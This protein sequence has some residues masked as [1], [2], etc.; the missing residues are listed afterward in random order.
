MIACACAV[1]AATDRAG[2]LVLDLGPARL[3]LADDHQD[4]LEQVDRL[5]PRD[6]DRDAVTFGE[7]RVLLE[8]HHGA[9]VPGGEEPLH[10]VGRRRE[11]GLHRG[12]DEDVRDQHRE[13]R[14]AQPPRL[15]GR[16]GRGGRGGLEA[17]GEED[18]LPRR[19]LPRDPHGIQ[20]RV[21]DPHVAPLG[22]DAEQVASTSRAPAACR[23]TSR[24]SP[25]AARRSP[26][27]GRSAPAGSRRPGS[28]ARA[29]AA[30][31]SGT[32]RSM[33]L[34]TR[35][36]VW[37]PQ[38]SMIVQGRVAVRRMAPEQALGDSRVAVFVEVFHG[39]SSRVACR[40]PSSSRRGRRSPPGR[41]R[42]ARPR[43]GRSG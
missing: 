26:A 4:A 9:D 8:P 40:L 43:P 29:P 38:T 5:E 24:R 13:V 15:P 41:R 33:P 39:R 23:R 28:P 16:Q 20:R 36:C 30:S 31:P 1:P 35:V 11:D 22:P 10:A 42:P 21:D 32:S 6:D 34:R 7:G 2:V 3:E 12:R 27:P 14:Q 19:V 37:P 18:H 17:D 25:P